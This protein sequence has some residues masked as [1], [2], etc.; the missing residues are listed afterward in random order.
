[1]KTAIVFGYYGKDNIGDDAML[2]SIALQFKKIG[3]KTI[4]ASHNPKKTQKDFRIKAV[5]QKTDF[6][7]L[8]FDFFVL[9]GGTQIQDYRLS[10]FEGLVKRVLK[11]KKHGAKLCLLGTGAQKLKTKKGKTLARKL[12]ENSELIIMRDRE[13]KKALEIAGVKQKIF[14]CA[15]LTFA[16]AKKIPDA[17]QETIGF[18]PIPYFEI[19]EKSPAKDRKLA[20]KLAEAMDIVSEKTNAKIE[21][22][23]FFKKYDA[24]FIK[25]ILANSKSK[26]LKEVKYRP[27]GMGLAKKLEKYS[28]IAGMRFHS[29]VFSAVIGRP[30]AAIALTPKIKSL[31]KKLSW[32]KFSVSNDFSAKELSQKIILVHS[33][34]K[35]LSKKIRARQKTL[36]KNAAYAFELFEKKLL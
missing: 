12:C 13:S 17:K 34:K 24:P 28:I 32:Q 31:V 2:Q 33:Q 35:K 20:K 27:L 19:F 11:A 4:A 25:M 6:S 30:F 23:P 7:K 14:V 15:D 1:M 3:I 21:L 16:N 26:K 22:I 36:K 8:E 5:S 9:G 10:G 29:I 18:C